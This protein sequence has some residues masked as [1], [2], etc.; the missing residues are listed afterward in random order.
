VFVSI[1]NNED[2]QE[3]FKIRTLNG[4]RTISLDYSW[5]HIAILIIY[6][7][8]HLSVV[9]SWNG[10]RLRVNAVQKLL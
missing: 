8:G 4:I 10:G 1:L 9:F 5:L 6:L 7:S 3:A 2:L